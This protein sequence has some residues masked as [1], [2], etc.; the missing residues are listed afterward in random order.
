MSCRSKIASDC[1]DAPKSLASAKRCRVGLHT[2]DFGA[3]TDDVS[4]FRCFMNTLNVNWIDSQNS[5]DQSISAYISHVKKND[6]VNPS[7]FDLVF[8]SSLSSSFFQRQ[9][10]VVVP[11]VLKWHEVTNWYEIDTIFK[12]KDDWSVDQSTSSVYPKAATTRPAPRAQTRKRCQSRASCS[13]PKRQKPTGYKTQSHCNL[14]SRKLKTNSQKKHKT[15]THQKFKNSSKIHTTRHNETN[16]RSAHWEGELEMPVTQLDLDEKVSFQQKKTPFSGFRFISLDSLA[17]SIGTSN[18][19]YAV[20]VTWSASPSNC[21]RRMEA[22]SAKPLVGLNQSQQLAKCIKKKST[23]VK[24]RH[25]STKM[26]C[27][28]SCSLNKTALDFIPGT[29]ETNVQDH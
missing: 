8:K 22:A 9:I 1:R 11:S 24:R 26:R 7:L 19:M 2:W 27:L 13:I 28:T 10:Q 17:A 23:I 29:E 15:K 18:Q 14:F 20:K 5:T 12:L 3:M 4:M 25:G 6:V 21:R 16:S